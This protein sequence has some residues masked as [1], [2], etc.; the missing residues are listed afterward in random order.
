MVYDVKVLSEYIVTKCINDRMPITNLYLQKI[1]YCIQREY[2]RRGDEI[3]R[4]DFEAWQIG[5]VIPSVYYRF[6]VYGG[7]EITI[8]YEIHE[9]DEND[10]ETVHGIIESKR[11]LEPWDLVEDVHR[12]GGAW[13]RIYDQGN[14]NRCVIPKALIQS[15]G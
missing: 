14:G 15:V 11:L 1:L 7:F 3:F 10:R 2:L 8:P 12:E 9:I 6:C 4:D 5:P 13:W